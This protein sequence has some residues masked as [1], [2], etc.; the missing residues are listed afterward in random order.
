MNV[1]RITTG[2]DG[3]SHFE[4]IDLALEGP[5]RT[6]TVLSTDV[7]IRVTHAQPSTAF[8]RPTS[9]MLVITLAGEAD[10]RCGDGSTKHFGPGDVLWADDLEGEGHQTVELSPSRIS[11]IVR[12]DDDASID[13]WRP[14]GDQ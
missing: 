4:D 10:V 12:L 5:G 2:R 3:R 9:R 11:L 13:S 7:F 1:V 8:H 6:G 14:G